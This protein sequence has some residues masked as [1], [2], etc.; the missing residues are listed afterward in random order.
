MPI[1]IAVPK[2]VKSG[3][4]RV[5]MVPA[6]SD[7]LVKMNAKLSIEKD[8][9]STIYVADA[10][11]KDCEVKGAKEL[12]ANADMVL[13]IQP[14]TDKE[15]K[16]MKEG[17]VLVSTLYPHSNP[18]ILKQLNDKK[19]TAFAL[20]RVP[21]ISRAQSM[22]VLSSQAAV[23]GYKAVLMAA[24]YAKY[25]FPMLTTAAGTVRPAKVMII[26]AGVA[27][28]QAIATAKRLGAMV[29]AYDVR[30]AAKE[31]AESLGAK[32]VD[33]GIKATGEGGYARELSAEEKKAQQD[34]LA[35]HI[36]SNN[37]IIT[38]AG[39]PGR[40]APK[41]ITKAMVEGMKPGSV[42]IDTVA[43]MGGNCELTKAGEVVIHNGVT[44]VGGK[45]MASSLATHASEMFARN[46]FNFISPMLTDEGELKIDWEDEVI[47]G[48]LA[49][50]DGEI[51]HEAFKELA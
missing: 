14:P 13:K 27:G 37:V 29:S 10:D 22:D 25:F 51:T 43:E 31:E 26:G 38:T 42:I 2:E 21:R 40:P 46:I 3:E 4:E 33:L 49:T 35:K 47:K 20:E 50:R 34:A 48:A 5:A 24:D 36:A 18:A 6:V 12:L 1:N 41:I 32:F 39:V 19:I 11:F 23:V 16:Q 7:K 8:V 44:I 30:D 28:L 9:G 15:I 17:A 45:D